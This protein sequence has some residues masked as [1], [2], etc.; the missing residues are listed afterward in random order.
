[1]THPRRRLAEGDLKVK[2]IRKDAEGTL[3]FKDWIVVPKIEVLKRKVLDEADTS[4]YSIHPGSTKMYHDLR[5][6]FWW[7]SLKHETALYVLECD[8]Y[9][10]VK[11]DY[12][13]PRGLF[14]LLSTPDWKWEDINIDFI[15]GL[16]QTACKFDSMWVIIDSPNLPTLY[17]WTPSTEQTS[18]LRCTLPVFYVC[19]EFWRWSFLIVCLSLLPTSRSNCMLP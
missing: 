11:A 5:K 17:L 6:Q 1:M 14:Q 2:R 15:V 16:P 19:M 10:K 7:T 13:K 4:M 3:W 8:T 9:S 18:M 12:M